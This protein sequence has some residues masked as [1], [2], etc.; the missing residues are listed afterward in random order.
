MLHRY[1]LILGSRSPRRRELL[2]WLQIPF[3]V[4]VSN[5]PEE[6]TEANPWDGAQIVARAKG[7]R[8]AA[9]LKKRK[10]WGH[11]FFP[12]IVCAD[13][14]VICNGEVLGKPRN[15]KEAQ[16]MLQ[17]LAGK[18]HQVITGVYLG[19]H[20]WESGEWREKTFAAASEVT[21]APLSDDILNNYL[22]TGESMDK[23]GAYGIQG[24]A[25]TFITQVNGSYSNVVGFP[26]AEFVEALKDFL[27]SSHDTQGNWRKKFARH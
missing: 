9:Q 5:A 23:A 8:L 19:A 24:A 18:S 1:N 6:F 21:F 15:K 22:A 7:Q 26:L 13:T 17:K 25:L 2:K 14:L 11:K 12:L 4:M 27:G 3:K 20:D 16:K 10:T